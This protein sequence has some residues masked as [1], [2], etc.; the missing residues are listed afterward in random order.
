M[1]WYINVKCCGISMSWNINTKH[2]KC[3]MYNA[4]SVDLCQR[5]PIKPHLV[6]SALVLLLLLVQEDRHQ[7]K[8]PR[9]PSTSSRSKTPKG[10]T[11]GWDWRLSH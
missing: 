2:V 4:K 9:A 3:Q 7:H 1:S 5:E 10:E 8:E 6:E 11:G